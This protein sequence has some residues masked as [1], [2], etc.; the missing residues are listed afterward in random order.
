MDSRRFDTIAGV[1]SAAENT[2]SSRVSGPGS[3]ALV[4]WLSVAGVYVGLVACVASAAHWRATGSFGLALVAF[5]A[6]G[7]LQYVVIQAMHESCH[8]TKGGLGGRVASILLFYAIGLTHA[9]RNIHFAHHRSFNTELDPDHFAYHRFPKSRRELVT[10]L[11]THATG[12]AAARQL[13]E[14]N[15]GDTGQRHTGGGSDRLGLLL[16]QLVILGAFALLASPIDYFVFWIAPLVTVAKVLGYLRILAE[17]GDPERGPVVRTFRCGA[18]PGVILGPYGFVRHA[19]HHAR[20]NVPFSQLA[21]V[22]REVDRAAIEAYAQTHDSWV[23][24]FHGS[25]FTLLARWWRALPA[26]SDV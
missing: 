17:H 8:Q 10:T 19:E 5:V 4:F 23:D 3:A 22:D 20:M 21:S 24:V 15:V 16:V 11:L 1:T 13:L 7:W 9:Y 25:H 12:Y 14:Q 2:P 18:I 26:R 6:I